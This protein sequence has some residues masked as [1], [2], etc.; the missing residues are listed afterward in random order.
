MGRKA[1]FIPFF[2]GYLT[3]EKLLGLL[4]RD[5]HSTGKWVQSCVQHTIKLGIEPTTLLAVQ[6][7]NKQDY[8]NVYKYQQ[9]RRIMLILSYT[10]ILN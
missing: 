7:S 5:R 4:Q 1:H 3:T 6:H 8:N 2:I 9:E 10:N